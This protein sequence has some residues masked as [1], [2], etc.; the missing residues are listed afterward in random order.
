MTNK[1]GFIGVFD[2]GI[3]GLTVAG[4]IMKSLPHEN[5]IYFG[6]TAHLPYGT[7]SEKQ[8][9]EYADNDVAF[10]SRFDLKA[11]V[12]ACNTA[13]SVARASLEEKYDIPIYGVIEPASIKAARMSRSHRIG[14]MAT[15]A[16]VR[17][18]AYPQTIRRYDEQAEVFQLA[19]PLL[20]PL[21]ENGRY[22]KDD[23]VVSTVLKEYLDQLTD[24]G[25]DTLVLGCTHYPLLMDAISSLVPDLTIISS[26][27]AAAETLHRGLREMRLLK[28]S[29]NSTRKYFVSDAPEHFR[30]NA[31]LFL[32]DE[33]AED[34]ELAVL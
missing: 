4:S 1:E 8:I 33:A 34:A 11:L 29:G 32:G 7:K 21:V 18:E 31:E 14:I 17:S 28:E 13:D 30:E 6:D 5:I 24:K 2:S 23:I 19:C 26:S 3:G 12:I 25:I 9:R 10:L 16:T 27:E 15:P 20:V 22:R